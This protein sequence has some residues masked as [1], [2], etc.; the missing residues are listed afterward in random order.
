MERER[1]AAQVRPVSHQKANNFEFWRAVY[2]SHVKGCAVCR[3][4]GDNCEW[5]AG[6]FYKIPRLTWVR[7]GN[8]YDA[9]IPP[10]TRP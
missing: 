8:P 7:P 3:A 4:P 10:G 1:L 2:L 9:D 5:G 6:L